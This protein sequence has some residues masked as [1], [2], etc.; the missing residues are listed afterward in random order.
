MLYGFRIIWDR[1]D[2]RHRRRLT[3]QVKASMR[4]L[5]IQ[6]VVLNHQVGSRLDL[7]DTDLDCPDVIARFGPLSPTALTRRVGVHPATMTGILDRLERA[8]WVN[9]ERHP[10]DRRGVVRALGQRIG[11]L[12]TCMPG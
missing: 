7:K 12:R 10:A 3:E 6:L 11:R 9:R 4:D 1:S 8:G 5:R 2:R